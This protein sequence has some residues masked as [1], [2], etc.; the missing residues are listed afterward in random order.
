MTRVFGDFAYGAGPRAGCFWDTTCEMPA[1]PR[2]DGALHADVA[3]IGAGFTGLNAAATLAEGGA[4]VVVLEA[5]QPGWGA[6][7]RNGGFC[8]LGGG[9]TDDAALDRRFG[10]D[11]RLEWRRTEVEAIEHVA[12]FLDRTGAQ[13]DR[14]SVG[15]TWLAHRS[16]DMRHVPDVLRAI[17]ENY[18][19]DAKVTDRG[20][21]ARAGL[22]AGFHGA[23]T[24][25]IGF[26]L[27]PRKYLAALLRNASASGARVYGQAMVTGLE[28]DGSCWRLRVGR[29]EVTAGQVIVA[30]NGYGSETIP[31]WLSG[32]FMPAQSSVG[33]TRVLTAQELDAQGWTSQQMCYD[34]RNLLHYF[35]LMPNG[36]MLFGVRGGLISSAA[37]E[38]A[39]RR[40]L[41]QDFRAMFPAWAHV[42]MQFFWSGMVCL[43][44]SLMPFVGRIPGSR[45]LWSAMCYH[46]NGVAMGS[47]CGQIIGTAVLND[48]TDD[49]PHAISGALRRFPLGR[50]RRWLMPPI[51]AGMW[52]R[53]L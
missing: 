12:A 51:Y 26:A 40:R 53:D 43:S 32:R 17:R 27:D 31:P 46:G 23:V 7:G 41:L 34:S 1:S 36:R 2:L 14:H 29:H 44:R 50:F 21:L 35:R 42:E 22:K 49:V 28:R 30:T 39:A 11:A 20:S 24:I 18:G 9:M 38:R 10:Q 15:E 52:L 33:V 6:S 19:V 37:S 8:C 5:E 48:R 4:S 25:P 47:Y 13:V 16:R 45:G 3:I